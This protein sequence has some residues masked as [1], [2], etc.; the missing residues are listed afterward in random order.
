[1][2]PSIFKA[3]LELKAQY[4]IPR[5][6]FIN[7]NPL[8]TIQTTPTKEWLSDGGLIKSLVLSACAVADKLLFGFR[9]TP[10]FTAL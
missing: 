9:Q 10:I 2:I 5:L 8:R 6:R 7:E 3:C 4:A 1:M